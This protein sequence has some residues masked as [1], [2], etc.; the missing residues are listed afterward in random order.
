MSRLF[1]RY[2]PSGIF[3]RS[4]KNKWASPGTHG[5]YACHTLLLFPQPR[6]VVF[7]CAKKNVDE[8]YYLT[9]WESPQVFSPSKIAVQRSDACGE[10]ES[11]PHFICPPHCICETDM[12]CMVPLPCTQLNVLNTGAIRFMLVDKSGQYRQFP[13]SVLY[14]TGAHKPTF[15]RA[16]RDAQTKAALL[17]WGKT[18]QQKRNKINSYV[19]RAKI[20]KLWGKGSFG[21]ARSDIS[22]FKNT[23]LSIL[24][25]RRMK[26]NDKN[27]DQAM[28]KMRNKFLKLEKYW[29]SPIDNN[30]DKSIGVSLPT[31]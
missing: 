23:L 28:K 6:V 8:K 9:F 3:W 12:K 29:Y 30:N 22:K 17:A 16:F 1:I 19:S 24:I 31:S 20:T 10:L 27:T 5:H 4:L 21:A 26:N 13:C 18:K 25:C 2:R 15:C 14:S 7:S 11:G